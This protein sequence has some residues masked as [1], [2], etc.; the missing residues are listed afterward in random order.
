MEFIYITSSYQ[1]QQELSNID[2][3][4]QPASQAY[5]TYVDP[6]VKQ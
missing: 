1:L 4:C 6:H 3:D 2:K 5:E